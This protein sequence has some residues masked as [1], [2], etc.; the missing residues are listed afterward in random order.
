MPRTLSI[1]LPELKM[2]KH[3][4]KIATGYDGVCVAHARRR[5]LGRYSSS[6]R[7]RA[8]VK[9]PMGVEIECYN[10]SGITH[11]VTH[12]SEYVCED[13]SL[14]SGGGEIKLCSPENKME[15]KAAD[16]VQ[17]AVIAGNKANKQCGLH[18]HFQRPIINWDALRRLKMFVAEIQD[19]MFDIVPKSRK[20][21]RYCEKLGNESIQSHYCWFS[22]SDRHPTYEIRIHGGT[23]NP[24]KVKGWINAWVQVRPDID[25]IVNGL[26]GW[27]D[28]VVSYRHDGFLKKL[29][30]NSIG[31]RYI[32]ARANNEGTLKNFGF[33]R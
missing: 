7:P 33:S 3:C 21:N 29:D 8:N 22:L 18:L 28:T 17:R 14:P 2:C 24:W 9:H 4:D 27:E 16:V 31:Y 15:D 6:P 5:S 23:M 32:K 10:P 13:G 25:K 1:S 30:P 11:Y 19:F 12:V 20:F 26:E